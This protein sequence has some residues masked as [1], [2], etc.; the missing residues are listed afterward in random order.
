M[1]RKEEEIT[2]YP[3]L[4]EEDEEFWEKAKKELRVMER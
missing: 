4:V 3:E 1:S 2:S